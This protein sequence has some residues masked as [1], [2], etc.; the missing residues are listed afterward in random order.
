MNP[1]E[2]LAAQ[3]VER[4]RTLGAEA[5]ECILGEGEEFSARVRLGQVDALTQAGSRA[6]GLRV[7]LGARAGSA[8]TSDLSPAGID[9]MIGSALGLARISSEDPCGLLP[10]AAELGRLETDLQL[11][12]PDVATTATEAK[13]DLARRAERAA[14]DFD[15]RIANA[16]GATTESHRSTHVFANSLGFTGSYRTTACSLSVVP[17]ARQGDA[18]ERDYWFT[19]GRSFAAL[20][21]AGHV[22][23]E[24]ARRALRRLGSRKVPTQKVPV[25][26]DPR[27]ARSL[28]QNL[29]EAVSGESVYRQGSF[30][31]G[32]LGSRIGSEHLTLIDDATLPGLFGTSPFDDEGVTSR[33]TVVIEKGVL[34]S[35]LL[36]CYTARKLGLRTTGN[37]SRG[38]TGNASVGP[39]NLFLPSGTISPEKLL[40]RVK[41]GYY[42]TE[43]MGFG[44]NIVTGDYSRGA[45]GLWI[46]NGELTCPVSEVTIS[47][48]LGEMLLGLEAVADDLEFRGATASPT[49]LIGEMTVSGH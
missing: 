36:N 30:L 34:K 39:G 14:L 37:A 22:G 40:G 23:R 8:Y 45:S 48:N 47:G 4:A 42:V 15:P 29:F 5:A 26:F 19:N 9:A 3:V 32:R 17:V 38:I 7:L 1:L 35:Y 13:I 43:L 20:E 28:V 27:V 10:E 18:M 24:A 6:V 44:V 46:E 33:R 2:Q 41:N 12:S 49:L 11:S 16:E 21:D 25:V 31:A